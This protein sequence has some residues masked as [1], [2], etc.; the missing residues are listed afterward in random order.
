MGNAQSTLDT[1]AS[2]LTWIG[3]PKGPIKYEGKAYY[4]E[5]QNATLWAV[6]DFNPD[7]TKSAVGNAYVIFGAIREYH[8]KIGGGRSVVGAPVS[9]E[10]PT[11]DGRGRFNQMQNGYIY[12]SPA[13]GAHEIYGNILLHWQGLGAEKSWLGYPISGEID[14][15]GG[16]LNSFENGQIIWKN[17]VA[18][19]IGYKDLLLQK[20]NQV[21]GIRSRLGL[22]STIDMPFNKVGNSFLMS[23]RGGNITVPFDAPVPVATATQSVKINWTGLECQVRQEKEDELA[24][25]VSSFAYSTNATNTKKF[26]DG[27]E[28]WKL[29]HDGARIMNT[30]YPIYEG[31]PAKV[32]LTTSLVELDTSAGNANA[33]TGR[34]VD[35]LNGT[36][37]L[38][39]TVGG[40]TGNDV[41][42]GYG[43][44]LDI[45]TNKFKDLEK[46]EFWK[47]IYN[48][49][50][51]PDDPYPAGMLELSWEEIQHTAANKKILR[52]PDDGHTILWTHS[53]SVTG[54]D[55]GGDVGVY[56]FYFDVNIINVQ[57]N[58]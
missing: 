40:A 57:Q 47:I 52:R 25:A 22:P 46:S 4:H 11:A 16:R 24:G 20:Y 8:L 33:V 23:F 2:Q 15:P 21:G 1:R 5:Y 54:R 37:T 14:T 31:P 35:F 36:S 53:I 45:W 48:W 26:P 30:N 29:G 51:S 28:P 55:D 6:G 50:D 7:I 42:S 17:G 56:V 49:F 44:E 41:A 43:R 10:T 58:L 3:A 34:V 38:L 19:A 27:Q 39:Q 13:T 9:D 32:V 12:W 18:S